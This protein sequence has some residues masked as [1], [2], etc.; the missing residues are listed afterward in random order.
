MEF[1]YRQQFTTM[2]GCEAKAE[3]RWLYTSDPHEASNRAEA[4]IAEAAHGAT[5]GHQQCSWLTR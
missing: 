5:S 1:K 3:E 4:A 2:S